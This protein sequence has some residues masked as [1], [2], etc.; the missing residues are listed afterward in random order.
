[1]ASHETWFLSQDGRQINYSRCHWRT[2]TITVLLKP[3]EA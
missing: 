3:P 1:M 2:R